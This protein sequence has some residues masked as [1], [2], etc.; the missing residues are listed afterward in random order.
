MR[1]TIVI[2]GASP[3]KDRYANKAIHMAKAKGLTPV[4][5]NPNYQE[6][7]GISVLSSLTEIKEKADFL[8][9]YLGF[10]HL[11]KVIDE[12]KHFQVDSIILNPGSDSEEAIALLEKHNIPIR[13]ACTLVLMSTNQIGV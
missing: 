7:D 5:V 13:Q 4:L 10:A 9:I 6:I 3:N 11:E 2:L 12:I 1:K 8:S